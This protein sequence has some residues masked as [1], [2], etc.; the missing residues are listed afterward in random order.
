MKRFFLMILASFILAG[1]TPAFKADNPPGKIYRDEIVLEGKRVPLPAGDWKVVVS[2]YSDMDKYVKVYLMKE[3][4][5]HKIISEI[6]ITTDSIMN[7]FTGY[8]PNEY[9]QRTDLYY[10]SVEMNSKDRYTDG[11]V[12]N[13]IIRSFLPTTATLKAYFQYC[14]DNNI[15]QPKLMIE[16]CHLVTGKIKRNKYLSISY[17]YNPE[18]EGFDT[19]GEGSWGTSTWHPLR[20]KADPKKV[21]YIERI[22]QEGELLHDRIRKSFNY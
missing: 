18:V 12:I 4:T 7:D 1:C 17:S 8:W 20:I 22:K 6:F 11:W 5:D 16:S 21:E 15:V 10:S 2:E 14:S 9:L 3:S 13:H 19:S